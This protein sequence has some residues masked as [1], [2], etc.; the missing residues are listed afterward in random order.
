MYNTN[1]YT[2]ILLLICECDFILSR[3][4]FFYKRLFQFFGFGNFKFQSSEKKEKI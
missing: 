2:Y 3:L 4:L 1:T